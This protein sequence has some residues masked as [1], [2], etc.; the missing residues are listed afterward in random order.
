MSRWTFTLAIAGTVPFVTLSASVSLHIFHDNR[1]V[2]ALLL[3]YAALIISFLGGVHW[4]VAVTQYAPQAPHRQ[5]AYFR[6][7]VAVADCSGAFCFSA[8]SIRSC[9]F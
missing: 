1:T 9:W 5:P 2:I 4:G 3:T 6:K 7:P 8:T